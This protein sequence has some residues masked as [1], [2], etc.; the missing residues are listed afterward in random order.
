MPP[1]SIAIDGYS[2]TGK[3]TLARRLA[4]DL[5][6]IYI[7]S[8]AMYRA[9]TYYAL[10]NGLLDE[11]SAHKPLLDSLDHIDLEFRKAADGQQAHIF[12]NCRDVEREIRTL[13]VSRYVSP[14]AALGP[15]RK[16]LVALQRGMGQRGGVVMDGRDIGTV[17]LPDAEL[18]IFMTAS[19]EIRA[20]R[21]YDELR[22]RGDQVSYAEVL[23]NVR[24]RDHLDSTREISP[25][26]Q[27][28]DAL[29]VDNSQ[30]TLEEQYGYV[31]ELVNQVMAGIKKGR[32]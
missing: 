24:Q 1:I 10:S 14:V 23:E 26:Q 4:R 5:G 6:Y 31:R 11:E 13:E 9:V 12:L 15:V 3:S 19:P 28:E 18:K 20:E 22:A 7:D 32:H 30:M 29:V 21:R 27:A 16:K 17:V 25:L 2:S 8:G